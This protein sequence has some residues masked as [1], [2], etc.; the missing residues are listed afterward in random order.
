MVR[1]FKSGGG[2]SGANRIGFQ[3]DFSGADRKA[4]YA[5]AAMSRVV[6][7]VNKDYAGRLEAAARR[8]I[9][10]W[11]NIYNKFNVSVNSAIYNSISARVGKRSGSG[12]SINLTYDLRRGRRVDG[13][14]YH[15]FLELSTS[16]FSNH[17]SR[18]GNRFDVLAY[19]FKNPGFAWVE[20]KNDIRVGVKRDLLLYRGMSGGVTVTDRFFM[21]SRVGKYSYGNDGSVFGSVVKW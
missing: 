13:R 10:N 7:R 9:L 8:N 6:N 5:D 17:Y 20:Y 3:V 11:G 21:G 14:P 1:P 2:L 19:T 15:M 18:T 16:T 4:I 12:Y